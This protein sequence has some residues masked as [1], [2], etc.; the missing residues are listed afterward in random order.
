MIDDQC[1]A[2]PNIRTSFM[3]YHNIHAGPSSLNQALLPE[4]IYNTPNS[5]FENITQQI[6]QQ[7]QH[8]CHLI[9]NNPLISKQLRAIPA[10]GAYYVMVKIMIDEFDNT[11]NNDI[12]LF[13]GLLNQQ[14]LF[15]M[16]GSAFQIPNFFRG[17]V[18][19]PKS[20]LTI[21]VKRIEEFCQK[22]KKVRNNNEIRAKL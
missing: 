10:S 21:A 13:E 4:I 14:S 19:A 3:N 17:V 12:Q 20:V 22:H 1:K 18:C 2:I 15:I 5:F 7:S 6:S 8:F 16:P 9:N 11:V